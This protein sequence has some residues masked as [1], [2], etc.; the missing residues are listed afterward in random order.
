[1]TADSPEET[2]QASANEGYIENE[3]LQRHK[4]DLEEEDL[5]H[6]PNIDESV[7]YLW[8]NFYSLISFAEPFAAIFWN[9]LLMWE[10]SSSTG[11]AR[12]LATPEYNT[13]I[14]FF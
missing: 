1:M 8:Y 4:K 13:G 2:L 3:Q 10:K 6:D 5:L 7:T 11:N 14:Y 12:K 9:P